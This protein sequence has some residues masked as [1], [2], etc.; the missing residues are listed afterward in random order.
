MS[1]SATLDRAI[2]AAL[3]WL[4]WVQDAHPTATMVG[5][6]ALTVAGFT[7]VGTLE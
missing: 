2:C 6:I 5:F 4:D 3:D 7:V 1:I